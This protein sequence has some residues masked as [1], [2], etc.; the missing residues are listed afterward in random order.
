MY[1]SAERLIL[2]GAGNKSRMVK[3]FPDSCVTFNNGFLVDNSYPLYV[4]IN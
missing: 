3:E 1:V 4:Q 2:S